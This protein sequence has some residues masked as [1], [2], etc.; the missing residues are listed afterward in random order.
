MA[1]AFEPLSCEP[2]DNDEARAR[3][4]QFTL[5]MT[6]IVPAG[7]IWGAIYWLGGAHVAAV[8]PLAYAA[9]SSTNLVILR[10][11][12]RFHTY[13]AIELALIV[14]LPIL[15]QVALGGFVAG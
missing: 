8:M 11:T 15:L 1:V 7:L 13:Q 10:R 12:H 5:A 3:K 4:G 14:A 6:L 2:N 9:L